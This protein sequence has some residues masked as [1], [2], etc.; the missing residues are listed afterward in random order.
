[1]APC[2]TAASAL[3]LVLLAGGGWTQGLHLSP[4]G[5]VIAAYLGVSCAAACL[6]W[7]Y[8][9]A[10]APAARVLP[11]LACA[12][13]AAAVLGA[14]SLGERHSGWILAGLVCVAAGLALALRAAPRLEDDGEGEVGATTATTAAAPPR[15]APER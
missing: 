15:P 6:L 13:L 3:L 14:H 1:V 11:F 8:A 10:R 4:R 7:Q 12:P 2:A 5:W 9:L